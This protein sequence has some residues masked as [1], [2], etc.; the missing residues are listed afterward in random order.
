LTGTRGGA[1]WRNVDGSFYDFEVQTF[2][3]TNCERLGSPPDDWGP[4]SLRQWLARLQLDA[5]FDEAAANYIRSAALI[6]E[7]YRA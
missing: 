1:L 4:R 6:E 7:V 2:R 5:G 3:G